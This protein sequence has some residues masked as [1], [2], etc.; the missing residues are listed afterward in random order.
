MYVARCPFCRSPFDETLTLVALCRYSN[1]GIGWGS[2]VFGFIGV[3]IAPSPFLFYK[4]GWRLRQMSR[5]APCLDVGLREQVFEEERQENE[6]K[7]RGESTRRDE[8][9]SGETSPTREKANEKPKAA[10]DQRA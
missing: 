1:L 9:D 7:E 6:R 2:S 10:N 3:A 4:Y 5:F 8:Q